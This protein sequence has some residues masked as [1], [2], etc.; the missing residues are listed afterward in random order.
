M[1]TVYYR[2]SNNSYKKDKIPL[3][4]KEN[5]LIN[6]LKVFDDGKN[7]I[8]VLGDNITDIPLQNFLNSLPSKTV[9]LEFSRLNNAQSFRYVYERALDLP[10]T[11]NV[12]FV[13]DDYIHLTSSSKILKEGLSRADYASLY[14]H[15]DKYVDGI[16]PFI[17]DMG[18]N[19]KVIKTESRH[20]KFTNSTTMTFATCVKTLKEDKEIWFSFLKGAH[21]HDFYAFVAL[22]KK[23]RTLVTPIP[24]LA[25]HAEPKWLSPFV[26]WYSGEYF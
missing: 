11:T 13:E 1:F 5:C 19:T 21:P 4:T 2:I 12:Y 9:S 17:K 22:L 8:N 18:E 23:G 20:W 26:D 16:N 25:T 6:F 15:P 24:T 10:D 3:A 7:T 14:D